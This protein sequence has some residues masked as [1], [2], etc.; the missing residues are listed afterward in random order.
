MQEVVSARVSCKR[1]RADPGISRL[2]IS[3]GS[4]ALSVHVAK[5]NARAG[6]SLKSSLLKKAKCL[7]VVL[8]DTFAP[9]IQISKVVL[10]KRIACV[11]SFAVPQ[12]RVRRAAQTT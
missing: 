8:R 6:L 1:C 3:L 5:F 11:R 10:A 9:Q 4:T 12:R 2:H 7:G